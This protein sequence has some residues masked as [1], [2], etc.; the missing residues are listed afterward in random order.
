MRCI[1]VC[2]VLFHIEIKSSSFVF[3]SISIQERLRSAGENSKNDNY[4]LSSY[5]SCVFSLPNAFHVQHFVCTGIIQS[6][7][8][9]YLNQ[10]GGKCHLKID[11]IFLIFDM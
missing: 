1:H 2:T 8:L 3:F 7:I 5:L 11:F 6:C 10:A 4:E 9:C